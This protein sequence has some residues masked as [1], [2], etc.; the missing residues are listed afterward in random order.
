M[1]QKLPTMFQ[2]LREVEDRVH[3]LERQETEEKVR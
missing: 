1:L 2:R 3:K